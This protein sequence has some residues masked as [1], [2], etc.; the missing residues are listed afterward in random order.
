MFTG[1]TLMAGTIGHAGKKE[2][3]WEQ[4]SESIQNRLFIL[5]DDINCYPG[6]GPKTT[7]G[8]ER[9]TNIFVRH[10]PDVIEQWF[11]EQASGKRRKQAREADGS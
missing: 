11:L 7:I 8:R 4:I 3:S 2:G 6:H 5:S 1:D 10:H 9:M